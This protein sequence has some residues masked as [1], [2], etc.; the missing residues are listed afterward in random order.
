VGVES[1]HPKRVPIATITQIV[2]SLFFIA[3]ASGKVFFYET[4]KIK[5][6]MNLANENAS[7]GEKSP[8]VPGASYHSRHRSGQSRRDVAITG[9]DAPGKLHHSKGRFMRNTAGAI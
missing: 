1:E 5:I 3:S 6:S 4:I 9:Q 2:V 7:S 8:P